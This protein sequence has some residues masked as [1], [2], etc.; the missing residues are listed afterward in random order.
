MQMRTIRIGLRHFLFKIK[1]VD[2]DRELIRHLDTIEGLRGRVQD[3]D[4]VISNPQAI[5]YI[6]EFMHQT[7]LL[8]QFLFAKLSEEDEEAPDTN[9]L[10]EGLVL[11]EEDDG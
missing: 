6:A 11:D 3:Y 8:Q 4:A 10:L 2:S 5:R 1:Q 9:T 7:G